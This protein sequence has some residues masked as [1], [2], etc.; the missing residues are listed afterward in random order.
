VELPYGHDPNSFF[1]RGA[2]GRQFQNL[3]EEAVP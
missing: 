3:L 2:D 1:T